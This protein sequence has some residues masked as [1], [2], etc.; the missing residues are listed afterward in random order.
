M[1][2]DYYEFTEKPFTITPNP[3]FIFLSG[4]HREAFAHLMYGINQH[5]GFIELT[6]EVGTGKTTVLRTLLGQL[7]ENEYRTA[8][9]FNPRLSAT[10]LLRCINREFGLS[11]DSGTNE[12]LLQ[13]LYHFLL[14]ENSQGRTVVLVIDEAQNL[15]PG[16]LEQIRLVSNLETDTDKL[17]QIILAGQ[18]E[19]GRLLERP[20][21][22]QLSQRITVR[23]HLR[24]IPRDDL[25]A[26][27]RHRLTIA[28]CGRAAEFTPSALR[29]IFRYSRGIPRLIN[30]VCDRVLLIGYTEERREING[31]MVSDA[32][33]ELRRETGR[34][35]E[36]LSRWVLAGCLLLFVGAIWVFATGKGKHPSTPTGGG[37][38]TS[39][40]S[41][42]ALAKGS[43]PTTAAVSLSGAPDVLPFNILAKVWNVRPVTAYQGRLSPSGLSSLAHRR[44]LNLLRFKGDLKTLL[45]LDYPALLELNLP[46]SEVRYAALTRFNDGN[47]RIE[48]P[49]SGMTSLTINQL[50]SIWTG[51]AY[52]PWMNFNNLPRMIQPKVTGGAHVVKLQRMLA[53]GGYYRGEPT[54]NF[55]TVTS[56]AVKAFQRAKGISTDGRVGD[57]TLMLL[58]RESRE[59]SPPGLGSRRGAKE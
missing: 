39:R 27:I 14:R 30:I 58:Y 28:G 55:D 37:T 18:P 33:K 12:E 34:D 1:Y 20:D 32:I 2:C 21:L 56:A 42:G 46:G 8:L 44:G 48:P 57:L 31:R 9:I 51:R 11:G 52:L 25:A 6:G 3:R 15:E 59:F 36:Q 38:E 23:Y 29:R 10:E 41:G 26:Y 45:R 40:I 19:L 17:I 53:Y 35:R 54:G 47:L 16:V 43:A 24:A 50:G 22:R 49:I 7:G 4:N 5:A 13:E